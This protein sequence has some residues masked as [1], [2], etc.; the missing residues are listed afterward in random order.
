[1]ETDEAVRYGN[2]TF[3]Y[4]LLIELLQPFP[5]SIFPA[6][7]ALFPISMRAEDSAKLQA[8]HFSRAAQKRDHMLTMKLQSSGLSSFFLPLHPLHSRVK[9]QKHHIIS[10]LVAFQYRPKDRVSHLS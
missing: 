7:E 9:P 4:A 1:M 3:L 6:S 2:N 8:Q 5:C 10:G